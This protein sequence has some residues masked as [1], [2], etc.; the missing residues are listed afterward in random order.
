MRNDVSTKLLIVALL[1]TAKDW[2][3]PKYPSVGNWLTDVEMPK[4]KI[5][6][7]YKLDIDNNNKKADVA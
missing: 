3:Q 7:T 4:V 1:V 5:Q 6:K 2:K